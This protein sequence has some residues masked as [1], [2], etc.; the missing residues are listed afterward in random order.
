[1]VEDETKIANR[2]AICHGTLPET[3]LVKIPAPKYVILIVVENQP[4]GPL[5]HIKSNATS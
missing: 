3:R 2:R 4:I 1:M 5:K